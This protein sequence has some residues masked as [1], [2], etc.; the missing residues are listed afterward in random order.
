MNDVFHS[1]AP[2]SAVWEFKHGNGNFKRG[3]LVGLRE[4]KRRASRHT[5][6]TKDSFSANVRSGPMTAPGTPNEQVQDNSVEARL[7][8][9]EQQLWDM[10]QRMARMEE[11][12]NLLGNRCRTMLDGL[13]RCHQVVLL[14]PQLTMFQVANLCLVDY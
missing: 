10:S 2:D 8:G 13:T 6:T 12:N 7:F 5:L 4:I 14:A 9:L 1:S 3:D 11:L